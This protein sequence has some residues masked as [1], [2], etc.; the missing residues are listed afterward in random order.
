[1]WREEF[2]PF[3]RLLKTARDPA[4][5]PKVVSR[6]H[7]KKSLWISWIT[8][9]FL[10]RIQTAVPYSLMSLQSLSAEQTALTTVWVREIIP[11]WDE[12]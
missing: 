10:G 11:N 2:N 7:D 8:L 9:Y 3:H 12:R 5:E 6:Q 4:S 1:L